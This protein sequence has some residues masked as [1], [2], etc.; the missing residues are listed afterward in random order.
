MMRE[1]ILTIIERKKEK[2]INFLF[3]ILI[4][5]IIHFYGDFDVL[6]SKDL[7]QTTAA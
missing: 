3:N 4:H 1:F 2:L 6:I 5:T 7:N